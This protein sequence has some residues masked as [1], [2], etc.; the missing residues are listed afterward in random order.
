M[1]YLKKLME[2]KNIPQL[3][4]TI[5]FVIYLVWGYK[6]PGNIADMIDTSSG[7]MI[8]IL[9]ALALFAYSNP[10]LGIIGLIVAYELI[11]R[12]SQTT[13]TA[14]LAAYYPTEAKK[15]SPF[16]AHHQ[17]PYTLEQEVVSKMAPV[18][19]AEAVSSPATFKP[20]LDNYHDAAPVN[21]TGMI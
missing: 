14:A 12:S 21:Y 7:K 10:I 1:E 16:S 13:G 5:L 20:I 11:K 3:I 2:K 18:R 19:N 4:L 9:V 17:F 15:W 6:M 8:V